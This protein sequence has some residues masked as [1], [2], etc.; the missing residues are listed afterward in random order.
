[1]DISNKIRD[2]SKKV[3]AREVLFSNLSAEFSNGE[4]VSITGP[5]GSGKSTFLKIIAAATKPTKGKIEIQVNQKSINHSDF[6]NYFGYVAPYLNL[7]EEF[8]PLEHIKVISKILAVQFDAKTAMRLLERFELHKHFL[9]PIRVFSS[10]MKQ[11][12]R[13]ILSILN[14]PI[15]LLLDEPFS[16]LDDSGIEICKEIIDEKRKNGGLI[17]IAS[18]DEREITLSSKQ[19]NLRN[20][21]N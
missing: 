17:L 11:R 18:N 20:F 13:F 19:I 15:V 16:N 1:M 14:D 9:K 3:G 4:V 7:Y 8:H 12:M 6:H 5:N 10:G 2:L 21:K